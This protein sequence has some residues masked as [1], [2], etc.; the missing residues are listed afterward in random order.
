[1]C[2]RKAV[3][4]ESLSSHVKKKFFGFLFQNN[5]LF[6]RILVT[7]SEWGSFF[8]LRKSLGLGPTVLEWRS[9]WAD[10]FLGTTG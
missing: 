1:M 8:T 5:F 3:S 4:F 2:M 10:G 7:L 9:E 6:V